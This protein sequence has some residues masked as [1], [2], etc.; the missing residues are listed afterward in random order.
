[1][2]DLAVAGSRVI[3]RNNVQVFG[4]AG[5]PAVVFLHGF[6]SD[7]SAW[8]PF[9]PAFSESRRV[10]LLDHVGAGGSDLG[11]YDRQKHSS[12]E[13]YVEDLLEVITELDLTEVTVV[14]HSISAMMAII[15]SVRAPHVFERLV[16]VAPSPCYIDDPATGYVG[17]FTRDDI[18]ELLVSLDANYVTWAQSVAPMVMGNAD[19][20]ELGAQLTGSFCATDPD[21]AAHFARVTFFS[22]VRELLDQVAVP[23]LV[24]Q[25]NDD[26]LAPL[27]AGR[28]LHAHLPD[29]TLV[30]L[31]ASGHCP[32]L[33]SPSE[34]L[35]AIIDCLGVR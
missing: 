33:S 24:L 34:T 10:V 3:T 7:Q 14:A 9:V 25:C 13:G 12:L 16:L 17:G 32:H 5:A 2:V 26:I 18:E 15:A 4:P 8:A 22:D 29:S 31:D 27:A 11:A 19:H 6:G 30:H 20:P 28:Y 35:A 23:A 21:I 1:M